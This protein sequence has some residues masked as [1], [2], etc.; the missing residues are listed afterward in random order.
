MSI[1]R[2]LNT[3]SLMIA[4]AATVVFGMP[5][6]AMGA[7]TTTK[8][9]TVNKTHDH[10]G[11]AGERSGRRGERLQKMAQLLNLTDDQAARVKSIFE[12]KSEQAMSLR[13]KYKGQSATS[14]D[15]AAMQRDFKAMRAETDAKLAQVLTADQMAK[16][17][18]MHG[19]HMKRDG[20]RNRSK[21]T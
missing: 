3:R 6:L 8:S 11:G 12:A 21:Q 10:E 15:K 5:L 14:E 1:I 16:Y 13:A 7:S 4:A 19:K 2:P 17:K 20:A 18:Q 9:S